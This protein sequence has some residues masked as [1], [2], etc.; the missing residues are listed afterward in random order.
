M[1]KIQSQLGQ[2][3]GLNLVVSELFD[4][5]QTHKTRSL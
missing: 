4:I 5:F 1:Q 2:V 3:T